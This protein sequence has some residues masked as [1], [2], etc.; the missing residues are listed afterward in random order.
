MIG[1]ADSDNYP[2]MIFVHT[3]KI[4]IGIGLDG[5][6]ENA[7]GASYHHWDEDLGLEEDLWPTRDDGM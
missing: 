5:G 4:T 7:D 2:Y 6:C 3:G 1:G